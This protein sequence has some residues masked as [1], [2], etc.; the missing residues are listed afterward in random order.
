MDPV[1]P[2]ILDSAEP[3]GD[4]RRDTMQRRMSV[5]QNIRKRLSKVGSER[6]A[7]DDDDWSCDS[8]YVSCPGTPPCRNFRLDDESGSDCSSSH[9]HD[10]EKVFSFDDVD[11][12]LA[13][14]DDDEDGLE[15][16]FDFDRE[17]IAELLQNNKAITEEELEQNIWESM[18]K[19]LKANFPA[20]LLLVDEEEKEEGTPGTLSARMT[21]GRG[22]PEAFSPKMTPT[23]TPRTTPKSGDGHLLYG[24]S[25]LTSLP[26]PTRGRA[27]QSSMARLS[28]AAESMSASHRKELA[29]ESKRMM[30][31][32]GSK[33]MF[34]A[35]GLEA[36]RLYKSRRRSLLKAA[37]VLGLA[38]AGNAIVDDGDLQEQLGMVQRAMASARK[39]H[40][41]SISQVVAKRQQKDFQ[42]FALAKRRIM[43]ER[44]DMLAT[45]WLQQE[46]ARKKQAAEVPGIKP[47]KDTK[48]HPGYLALLRTRTSLLG[49][50]PS[51]AGNRSKSRKR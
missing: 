50:P 47:Q 27:R 2:P 34:E 35:V 41:L 14:A 46:D 42:A 40:R 39:K 48:H 5:R 1:Q 43:R 22:T 10:I 24:N 33:E 3:L 13:Q 17:K 26:T 7:I 49:R 19:Q 20:S 15:G 51:R 11:R 30:D 23:T 31:K 32:S 21:P 25:E 45:K 18:Q 6:F 38:S 8:D 28:Y 9:C 16:M 44:L 29:F 4:K 37:E 12:F 36:S